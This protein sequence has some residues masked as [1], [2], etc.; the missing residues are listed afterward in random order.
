MFGS[1]NNTPF[2]GGGGAFG[3]STGGGTGGFG[4]GSPFGQPQQQ[5]QQPAFGSPAPFG[6]GAFGGATTTN[7]T[8]GAPT[9]STSPF[10]AAPANTPAFG[11]ATG[12][13][14][15]AFG[16][17][18]GSPPAANT[19]NTGL[20]G[21]ASNTNTTGAF[22][23]SSGAFGAA[24]ST[25]GGST[26]GGGGLF[27]NTGATNNT[28]TSSLFGGG[29]AANTSSAFGSNPSTGGAF[30]QSTGGVFGG[31]GGSAFGGQ[32]P[33]TQN[34]FGAQPGNLFGSPSTAPAP[35]TFG[36]APNMFGAPAPAPVGTGLF[37]GPA[38]ISTQAG[39]GGGSRVAPFQPTNRQDGTSNIVL[40]S[41]SAMQQYENQSFE[42]LRH[43]DYEQ[44]NRGAA[45]TPVAGN[46]AAQGGAFFGGGAPA[47]APVFGGAAPAPGLF[48]AP[49]PAANQGGGLFGSPAPAPATNSLFGG[50]GGSTAPAP[51]PFGAP[52]PGMFG[53]APAPAP[54]GAPAPS[55]P[56]L[57]GSPAPAAPGMF[58]ATSPAPAPSTFGAFGSTTPAPAPFGA[59]ASGGLFGA[60][61]PA[62]A[63]FGAFGQAP[64]PAGGGGLFG[65]APAPAGGE[66]LFGQA[67]APAPFGSFGQSPA[68]ATAFGAF[69]QPSQQQQGGGLFG[70]QQTPATGLFG[71]QQQ[72]QQQMM[73]MPQQQGM[74]AQA[75]PVNSN[76]IPPVANEVLEQQLRALQ[77]ER[78]QVEQASVW[79]GRDH[80]SS[81]STG[82]NLGSSSPSGTL[83]S[84]GNYSYSPYMAASPTSSVKIRPRGFPKTEPTKPSKSLLS[85][86]FG[87]DN[88]SIHT[89]EAYLRSAAT[90]L[91]IKTDALKNRP[92]RLTFDTQPS[93]NNGTTSHVNGG[94]TA[95]RYDD[96]DPTPREE[97]EKMGLPF[98][99]SVQS[100]IA[101]SISPR[102]AAT[103]SPYAAA[104]TP[105]DAGK[106]PA[107]DYYQSVLEETEE[108][109]PLPGAEATTKEAPRVSALVPKLTKNGYK[110]TPSLEEL[111]NMSDA[112]LA[113]VSNFSVSRGSVGKVEWIGQ[114][115]VRGADLD[116]I[117]EIQKGDISV[118]A[119]AEELGTKPEE[120]SKLNRPAILT[121][122]KVFPSEAPNGKTK[123]ELVVAFEKKLIKSARKLGAEFISYESSA[124]EWKIKVRH[125]SRYAI[126]DDSDSESEL[127]H[128]PP[129]VETPQMMMK[130]ARSI[131][132]RR[133]TPKS[134]SRIVA[135]SDQMDFS[136]G[137]S[138]VEGDDDYVDADADMQFYSDDAVMNMVEDNAK[139]AYSDVITRL[140]T[141]DSPK[142]VRVPIS[143]EDDAPLEEDV[144]IFNAVN[145]SVRPPT[146]DEIQ[147]AESMPSVFDELMNRV[148]LPKEYPR[149]MGKSFRVGWLPDGS[150][151][152]LGNTFSGMQSSVLI[153]SRPV[154][155]K[156]DKTTDVVKLLKIQKEF[157][158]T[159]VDKSDVPFYSLPQ[160]LQ[161]N[162]PLHNAL[163]ELSQSTYSNK[164]VSA[165]FRLLADL[166]C[167]SPVSLD[168]SDRDKHIVPEEA[169]RVAA[170]AELLAD[171]CQKDVKKS[172]TQA[173]QQNNIETAI[174]TALSSGNIDVAT[175]LAAEYGLWELVDCL[176]SNS[177]PN[178]ISKQS[179]ALADKRLIQRV[180]K[181]ALRSLQASSNANIESEW[182][183]K[184]DKQLNWRYR[185][186]L[187]IQQNPKLSLSE[188]LNKYE[189][190]K[191][192]GNAP[193]TDP[194]YVDGTVGVNGRSVLYQIL[195]L[196]SGAADANIP[197]ADAVEPKCW[198]NCPFDY[199]LAYHL[200]SVLAS[201]NKD[202]NWTALQREHIIDS[203]KCQLLNKGLWTWAVFVELS[204]F[205]ELSEIEK[206]VKALRAKDIVL[207][208]YRSSTGDKVLQEAAHV[209]DT[210]KDASLAGRAASEGDISQ[211]M[212]KLVSC[213]IDH[214]W[215]LFDDIF[216]PSIYDIGGISR[217][218]RDTLEYFAAVR[219]D[220]SLAAALHFLED[221]SDQTSR[222]APGD[223]IPDFSEPI[224]HI[225][226][227]L[228][229]YQPAAAS[230]RSSYAFL[231]KTKKFKGMSR[232]AMI[233]QALHQLNFIEKKLCALK[234]FG[235]E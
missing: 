96:I 204:G 109:M 224:D 99:S 124:G 201:L 104:T 229:T 164:E 108:Q 46:T 103:P 3:A 77:N 2:G 35:S 183:K 182:Y 17:T 85:T 226:K 181:T 207:R 71:Q 221:I 43:Q 10:G 148:K 163:K 184:G 174:F 188:L 23:A 134:S 155:S 142:S 102:H 1:S 143:F 187:L 15:G 72:P 150:F 45:S 189:S 6:G 97:A 121:F 127:D 51:A 75:V 18:F 66:G 94:T 38:P 122:F 52:A 65:Q 105:Q 76:I 202:S 161:P 225:R 25:F 93:L 217:D 34:V 157:S 67:P 167:V 130:R 178:D 215:V 186:A 125:F 60:P 90:N 129:P 222:L 233:V 213:D 11:Q 228:T 4:G 219:G 190:E 133:G 27:G 205:G 199:S 86:G 114:V 107:Y 110:V 212:L 95:T 62:P 197:L 179:I 49:A 111:A 147:Y 144:L 112:D 235:E 211:L 172:V 16:S 123:E 227:I 56:G 120:G 12:G 196:C 70:Q 162:G 210:W 131:I 78:K 193:P 180:S 40:H 63:A 53:S 84:P 140:S 116:D 83:F 92:L 149:S 101:L 177:L 138:D 206:R 50:F 195:R 48:G 223:D 119:S 28:Q 171:V 68:P 58:G 19:T 32:Q 7:T 166:L 57:F 5:Q 13:G 29:A 136:D 146:Q 153:K 14:G 20:F 89:P 41:I 47:A 132:H 21:G 169:R 218:N 31:G 9:S 8:F 22:G 117:I 231:I 81:P 154:L 165:S 230:D 216:L 44:G 36:A 39:G 82:A 200:L 168:L 37:G 151:L 54:F 98:A 74:M 128:V 234:W 203:Y 118:Y 191:S 100:P 69:G 232:A 159:L 126:C 141:I 158:Q 152:R 64:A 145:D 24:P 73:M 137:I 198:T 113:A 135:P 79:Q 160:D 170:V 88:G 26:G 185:F 139:K 175:E 115:D 194:I 87:R 176:S 173:I 214:A 59:P 80:K 33:A 30:G 192:F 42:E 55:V 156:D 61:S 208:N 220:N 209:P 91:V 106:S